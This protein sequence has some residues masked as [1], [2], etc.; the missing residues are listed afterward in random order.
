MTRLCN[1]HMYSYTTYMLGKQQFEYKCSLNLMKNSVWDL[2]GDSQPQVSIDMA[3][4]DNSI[5]QTYPQM[6]K[7]QQQNQGLP[8]GVNK[9]DY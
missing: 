9:Y 6:S 3:V 5:Q 7:Q 8:D 4:G 2:L 1:Q